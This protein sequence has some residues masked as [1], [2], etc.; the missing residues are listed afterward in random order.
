MGQ[1]SI[2]RSLRRTRNHWERL[3]SIDPFWAILTDPNKKNGGWDKDA[4]FQ[5]GVET[6]DD[7]ISRLCARF[8][9]VG[10]SRV[11]DFG[12]GVGR[13]SLGLSRHFDHVTGV[14]ISARMIDL[15]GDFNCHPEKVEYV[16]SPC[17]DLRLFGN[18]HFDLVFSLITLQHMNRRH[19]CRYLAEFV[20]VTKPG[21]YI[22]FQ[23]PS[24]RLPEKSF[25]LRWRRRILRS[26]EW[27]NRKLLVDRRPHFEMH[28]VSESTIRQ[29]LTGAGATV[30]DATRNSGSGERYLSMGYL[31]RKEG[32]G[33]S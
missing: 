21:G 31:A 22:L 13:L 30:I 5:S 3:A 17:S 10:R 12:C 25:R 6:V 11:L 4:F 15:A 8:D 27:V 28:M 1:K 14:D 23:M 24:R 19:A 26:I 32:G 29:V 9:D 7:E 16:H 18:D 33:R 2:P 20:R